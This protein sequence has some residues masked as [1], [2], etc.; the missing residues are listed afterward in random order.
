M[1]QFLSTCAGWTFNQVVK[2]DFISGY[3]SYLGGASFLLTG[4][5]V[6]V[7]M[8]IAGQ[9]D[10]TQ[11]EIGAASIAM[12]YRTIGQAGKSERLIAATQTAQKGATP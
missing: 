4:L 11:A 1:N 8:A 10:T 7:N 2:Q 9:W 12:G 3:R 5:I 6:F